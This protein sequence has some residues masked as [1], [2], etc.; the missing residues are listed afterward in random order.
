M[1]GFNDTEVVVAYPTNPKDTFRVPTVEKS[2]GF[3]IRVEAE[4]G[5]G[6][7]G[8]SGV[9]PYT[10][11]VQ[12]RNLTQF[13]LVKA[14]A[15]ANAQGNIG[16]GQTWN[17]SDQLFVFNVPG[18]S[19]DIKAGDLLEVIATLRAGNPPGDPTNDFSIVRS[20]IFEVI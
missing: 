7:T 6:V 9:T 3:D 13:K 5:N 18:G 10:A 8:P 20:E 14:T 12:I 17:T 2:L 19:A 1:P 15:P 4:A 16:V 11:A